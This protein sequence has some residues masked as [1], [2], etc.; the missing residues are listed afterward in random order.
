MT[1]RQRGWPLAIIATVI[2]VAGT[3]LNWWASQRANDR[4][5]VAQAELRTALSNSSVPEL[6]MD[7]NRFIQARPVRAIVQEADGVRVNEEVSSFWQSRCIIGYL[8]K[9]GTVTTEVLKKSCR[10]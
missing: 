1:R 3:S 2:L 5:T 9:D 4:A 10:G 8:H 6:V 7:P